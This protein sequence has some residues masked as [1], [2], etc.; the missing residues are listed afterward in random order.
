M[1]DSFQFDLV[2]PERLLLSEAVTAVNVP[3]TEG[4]FTVMAKHAPFMTTLKPGV[5]VATT[6]AGTE[7]RIFVIG[8]FADVSEGGFTLLAERA[9]LVEDLDP[10]A[11]DQQIKDAEEDVA[12]ASDDVARSK[13]QLALAQLREARAAVGV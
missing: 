4:Y 8:G 6:D 5:V 11:L 3:G 12:D 1:A 7:T 9:T 13:A 10:A 2:S